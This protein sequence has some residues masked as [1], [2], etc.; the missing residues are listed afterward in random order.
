MSEIRPLSYPEREEKE[1]NEGE[2]AFRKLV[3][4]QLSANRKLLMNM[5]KA[6]GEMEM[7]KAK[8]EQN[9]DERKSDVESDL[10]TKFD[11]DGDGVIREEEMEMGGN[12]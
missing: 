7:H 1:E 9:V 6:L 3:M 5:E 4:E 10:F 2:S 12:D 8:Q 11:V